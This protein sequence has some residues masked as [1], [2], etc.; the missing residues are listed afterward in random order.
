MF[1]LDTW[2]EV[3]ATLR[4]NVLRTTMTAW[5]VFW[6]AFMLVTMLG[7]GRGLE[8]GVTRNMAALE[9]N[10]VY[11]WGGNTSR[12]YAGLA[13]ARRIRLTVDDVPVLRALPGVE[14]V[15]PNAEVG[16]WR[17]G[18]NVSYGDQVSNFGLRGETPEYLKV[19][20]DRPYA[21][22]F[23]NETD[24][25]ERRKVVVLG[26]AARDV[27]IPDSVDP[28]GEY[29]RI[30][31]VYFLIVGVLASLQGGEDAERTDNTVFVPFTTFQSVFNGRGR[32]RGMGVRLSAGA[33]AEQ[34]EQLIRRTLAARHRADP[35]D[36]QAIGSMNLSRQHQRV[37]TL[38]RGV[39]GF[40]WFVCLCTLLAG[41]LGV[42]N[43]MLISVK[44]RTREF[45]VR[46]A[47][48][49]TPASVVA[50]VLQEAGLLTAL[51]GYL[52]VVAGVLGLELSSRHTAG[53]AGPLAP[54]S[55]ELTTAL[56]ATLVL[57]LAGLLAG[58][59]PARHAASIRPIVAL[60]SE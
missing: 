41:A 22:R 57:V 55:V 13:L 52:G 42:S 47:L 7:I 2:Q 27:L 11:V 21:G 14:A 59:A 16:G 53:E 25:R 48:G 39:Q 28:I 54:P 19:A 26:H 6:G 34:L 51:A 40:V 10:N 35:E 31:G 15:A 3:F 9:A 17:Q 8:G 23:I 49:A 4:K 20:V 43:I 58:I 30:R 18:S 46:K 29:V 5:G 37:R 1:D 60:R 45:G 24:M 56:V 44:E 36:P 32:V 12:P 38:F 33:D 50:L